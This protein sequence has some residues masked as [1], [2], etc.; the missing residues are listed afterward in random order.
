MPF[1]AFDVN[2]SDTLS[3]FS[4]LVKYIIKSTINQFKL[5]EQVVCRIC[6]EAIHASNQ[7]RL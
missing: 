3:G 6:R 7:F 1:S 4:Q 5:T 2:I